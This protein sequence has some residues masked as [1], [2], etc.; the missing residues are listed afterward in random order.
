LEDRIF[1]AIRERILVPDVVAYIVERAMV[2]TRALLAPERPDLARRT[3]LAEI[4]EEL[5]MLGRMAERPGRDR[6]VARLI[7]DLERERAELAGPQ[8]CSG[9]AIDVDAY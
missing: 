1:S 2:K 4:E 8:N 7:A 6:Q 3:R 9:E 5:A